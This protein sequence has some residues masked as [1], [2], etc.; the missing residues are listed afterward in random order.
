MERRKS[1]RILINILNGMIK[2]LMGKLTVHLNILFDDFMKL[3][4]QAQRKDLLFIKKIILIKKWFLMDV[5][6]LQR[7]ISLNFGIIFSLDL[8]YTLPHLLL[9]HD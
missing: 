2:L 3:I 5:L 1:G 4:K 7:N 8:E 6:M 9:L